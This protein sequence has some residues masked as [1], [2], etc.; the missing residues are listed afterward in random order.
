[1]IKSSYA[2]IIGCKF[3]LILQEDKG[4]PMTE[5]SNAEERDPY[6]ELQ[7]HLDQLPVPYPAMKSGVEISILK[8]IFTPEEARIAARLQFSWM[9]YESLESISERVQDLGYSKE[10]LEQL[11]D[12]MA[13]KG[14][15]MT[16]QD[17]DGNKSYGSAMLVFGMFEFQVNRLTRGFAEDFHAYMKEGWA[18]EVNK[19]PVPQLRVV[20]IGATID[21]HVAIFT[22]DDINKILEEIEGPIMVTNC[23]CRQARDIVE[24]PCKNTAR[25]EVCMGWGKGAEMYLKAGWGRSITKDEALEIL[26]Q[27]EK[28]GMILQ[29]SNSQHP[30]FLCSCCS[31]CDPILKFLKYL[32]TPASFTQ[33]NYFAI[34]DLDSCT[35]CGTCV[36]RC[37]M[38]A[39]TLVDDKASFDQNH[40][41]GCGNCV[42]V[43]PSEA[44]H[45]A[46]TRWNTVPP[47]NGKELYDRIWKEKNRLRELERKRKEKKSLKNVSE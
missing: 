33:S 16:Y 27:N 23:V 19:V 39:I 11:L 22:Y 5:S 17:Q 28:E 4:K 26:K 2:L 35:G 20:P 42:A 10:E 29:V 40:C 46:R 43:C 21:Q 44:I 24:K 13:E 15:L 25:R 9:E 45:L 47:E 31:C 30:E 41:I 34:N 32:P 14:G 36:E 7:E 6:R 18:Q 38:M 3:Y 37:Q 12:A 8:R 1:M